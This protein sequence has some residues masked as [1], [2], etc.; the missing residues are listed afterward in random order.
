[1]DV[2]WKEFFL[3]SV[4]QAQENGCQVKDYSISTFDINFFPE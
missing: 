4:L 2:Q 1:M 3:C